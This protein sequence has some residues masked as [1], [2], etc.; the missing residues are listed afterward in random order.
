MRPPIVMT[1]SVVNLT[2]NNHSLVM[3]CL[4]NKISFNYE[5]NKTMGN[6]SA[7]ERTMG[8]KS[9]QL[10]IINLKP[11]D[12]GDYRCIMSNRTGRIKSKFF[13]VHIIGM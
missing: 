8:I 1:D 7:I 5:W 9:P 10:T 6:Q 11:E 2:T 12:S 13:T 4:P 3:K